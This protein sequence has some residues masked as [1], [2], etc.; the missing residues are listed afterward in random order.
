[1]SKVVWICLSIVLFAGLGSPAY[2]QMYKW[3]D[4]KGTTHFADD[5]SKIPEPYRSGAE[6]RK[7]PKEVSLPENREKPTLPINSLKVAEPEADANEVALFRRHELLLTEVTLNGR[8][9]RHFVVDTGASFTLINRQTARELGLVVDERTPFIPI[10]TASDVIFTPLVTLQSVRVGNV[11]VGNVEA[12]IH[13][14]PSD[15]AGL[16]GNSFLNKFRV[17]IDSIHGK[18]TLF[19]M[20]GKPSPDRPGGYNREYWMGQFRF[21]QRNLSEL[22]KL[23]TRYEG[24]GASSELNRINNSIR[25]FENQLDDLERKASFAGVPRNWRE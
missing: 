15:M 3:V 24:R 9:K 18:M 6:I 25:F 13:N 19:S 22:K 16:L 7:V 2:G 20:Q 11:E 12:L 21:Y 23:R 5:L 10:F 17:V 4:E 14:M 8:V 1:M